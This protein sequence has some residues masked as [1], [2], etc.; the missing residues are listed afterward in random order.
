MKTPE[1]LEEAIDQIK[2][3]HLREEAMAEAFHGMT[4]ECS[5]CPAVLARYSKFMAIR[6]SME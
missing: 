1:T 3:L 2:H 4:N 6:G 5:T